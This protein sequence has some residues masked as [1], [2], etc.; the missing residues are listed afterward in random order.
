MQVDDALVD[1]HLETIPRLRTFSARRFTR[2][3]SKGF[4]GHTNGTVY[5]EI[6][7]PGRTQQIGAHALESTHIAT[8]QCDPEMV[9]RRAKQHNMVKEPAIFQIT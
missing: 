1:S 4:C 5:N 2:S 8:G 6:L 7:V 3:D 9:F